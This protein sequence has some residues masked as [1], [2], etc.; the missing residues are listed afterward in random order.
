MEESCAG[1]KGGHQSLIPGHELCWVREVNR[2]GQKWCTQEGGSYQWRQEDG[3][4]TDMSTEDTG[5]FA[6]YGGA[7]PEDVVNDPV[8]TGGQ[9]K[10]EAGHP[11]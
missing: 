3:E 1:D 5:E 7:S 9:P 10:D 2:K 8:G 4:N 11:I 6:N